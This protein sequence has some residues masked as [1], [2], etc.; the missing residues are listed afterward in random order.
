MAGIADVIQGIFAGIGGDPTWPLKMKMAREDLKMRQEAAKREEAKSKLVYRQMELHNQVM[1][2]QIEDWEAGK[3]P[4]SW[5]G[6]ETTEVPARTEGPP[7]T[8]FTPNAPQGFPIGRN[9]TEGIEETPQ[10]APEGTQQMGIDTGQGNALPQEQQGPPIDLTGTYTEIPPPMG[11]K[12][13]PTGRPQ[14]KPWL[15]PRK[16]LPEARAWQKE[17]AGESKIVTEGAIGFM[18]P[19]GFVPLP[20]EYRG[21]TKELTTEIKNYEKYVKTPGYEKVNFP[22]YLQIR[23]EAKQAMTPAQTANVDIRERELKRREEQDIDRQERF[24]EMQALREKM[25][26]T[27]MSFRET[28]LNVNKSLRERLPPKQRQELTD[29]TTA[30]DRYTKLIRSFKP[31]YAGK[32][33]LGPTM[34]DI[35]ARLGT[36]KERVNWWKEFFPLDA[37]LRHELFGAAFTKTETKVYDRI[38]I[39]ENL[40]PEIVISTLNTRMN[41][42]KNVFDREVEGLEASG[43]RTGE[44]K[45]SEK[46][47]DAPGISIKELRKKYNY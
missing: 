33:M 28:L 3:Q 44:H 45:I 40:D 34:T 29:K 15:V 41:V 42:L 38:T 5:M 39:N 23:D 25:F 46:E 19:K 31:E 27:T 12:T 13:V 24:Q 7:Q 2:H 16:D 18:T 6:Q 8:V 1:S 43:W 37:V 35:H 4:A 47:L 26:D 14:I 22:E 10:E 30:L 32:V 9:R 36:D 17:Q 11:T 20:E 21:R